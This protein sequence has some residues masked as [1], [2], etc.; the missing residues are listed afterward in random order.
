MAAL[1]LLAT[2]APAAAQSKI[3]Q[4]FRD[5]GRIDPCAYS[6]GELNRAK[7]QLPPDIQQYAP[8]LADQ[9]GLACRGGGQAGGPAQQ[10]DQAEAPTGGGSPGAGP[11]RVPDPPGPDAKPRRAIDVAAPAVSPSSGGVPAWLAVLIG[12]A[13]A[14]GLGGVLASRYG[15][16]DAETLTRPLRTGLAEAGGRVADAASVL[17]ERLRLGS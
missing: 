1:A 7:G 6:P 12:L 13:A 2:P 4:D 11:P 3:F 10:Q 14:L 8:G 5:D 9:L 15:G 17:R 16:L